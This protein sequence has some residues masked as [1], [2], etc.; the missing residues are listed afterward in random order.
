MIII[1]DENRHLTSEEIKEVVSTFL[2]STEYHRMKNY[3]NYYEQDNTKLTKK[4]EDKANRGKTPLNYIPTPYYATVV[5]TMSGYMFQNVQYEPKEGS[6]EYAVRLNEILNDNGQDVKDMTTG[7]YSLAFNHGIEWVYSTGEDADIKY[8]TFD[9]LEWALVYNTAVEP[10]VWC[11]IRIQE[12]LEEYYDQYIDVIYKDLWQQYKIKTDNHNNITIESR[13]E[14]QV[15]YFEECPVIDYN[16]E[17]IGNKSPFD[18]VLAYIVALDDLITSNSDEIEKL[19]EAL[20]LLG[21]VLKE[22]DLKALNELK[23]IQD[24]SPEE[25]EPKFLEKATSPEFREYVSKLLIQEIYRH[26]SVVDWYILL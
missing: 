15:L 18:C 21:R 5:D 8:A 25:F 4:V 22:E 1:P 3:K 6:E 17:I 13:A 14:D 9:P 26:S 23:A 2:S 10:D 11:A 19:T 24:L 7:T 12:A 16:S 20:L